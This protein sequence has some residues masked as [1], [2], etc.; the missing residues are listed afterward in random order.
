MFGAL[1]SLQWGDR[2]HVAGLF[3]ERVESLEMWRGRSE[4]GSFADEADLRDFLKAHHPVVVGLYGDL[5]DDPELAATLDDAFLGMI[6]LWYARGDRAG[7]FAQEA[8]IIVARKRRITP[9]P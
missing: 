8:M 1:S 7:T 4:L 9:V 3:G 6:N 5:G 2:E